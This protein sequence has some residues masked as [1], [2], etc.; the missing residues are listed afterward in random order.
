MQLTKASI[1]ALEPV[2][3][4]W[5]TSH[6]IHR[7]D[8]ITLQDLQEMVRSETIEHGNRSRKTQQDYL[9]S[10]LRFTHA[11]GP[12]KWEPPIWEAAGFVK[13]T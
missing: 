5:T 1:A 10:L 6:A 8:E 12:A 2:P 11:L 7:L 3:G 9:L 13:K 4:K